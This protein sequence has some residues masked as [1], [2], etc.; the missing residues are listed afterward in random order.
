MQQSCVALAQQCSS[1]EKVPLQDIWQFDMPCSQMVLLSSHGKRAVEGVLLAKKAR[2]PTAAPPLLVA[3]KSGFIMILLLVLFSSLSFIVL[4]SYNAIII[5]RTTY[6]SQF[7]WNE[8]F[9]HL[10]AETDSAK[11]I[12]RLLFLC[13]QLQYGST[14]E[15]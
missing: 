9:Q 4:L 3:T 14:M 2:S 6:R 11:A 10:K 13:F 12:H 7:R 1:Q 8:P 15:K 5:P